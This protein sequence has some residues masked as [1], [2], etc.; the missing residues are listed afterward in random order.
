VLSPYIIDVR[1]WIW[2]GYLT[3][4]LFNYYIDLKASIE[5]LWQQMEKSKRKKINSCISGGMEISVSNTVDSLDYIY[6]NQMMRYAEQGIKYPFNLKYFTEIFKDPILSKY[7]NIFI[8][9]FEGNPV[10]GVIV[11][12]QPLNIC[13]IWIGATKG[14]IGNMYPNELLHWKVIEWSKN[15]NFQ[16]CEIIGADILGISKFKAGFNPGLRV[17][18]LCKKYNLFGY[19]SE[20]AYTILRYLRG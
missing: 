13:S 16:Y 1:Q 12:K 3:S 19:I 11:L 6:K 8:I 18:F 2:N 5:S 15:N 7:I 9:N 14:K 10:G 17:N 4:P 20:K